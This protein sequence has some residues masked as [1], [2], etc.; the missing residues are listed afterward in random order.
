MLFKPCLVMANNLLEV[1][2]FR[3]LWVQGKYLMNNSDTLYSVWREA[4]SPF[5][6]ND[7]KGTNGKTG[8][9]RL[10]KWCYWLNRGDGIRKGK[11]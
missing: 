1:L 2:S 8:R 10:Y 7:K 3:K 5:S 9:N 4:E 11:F 6:E